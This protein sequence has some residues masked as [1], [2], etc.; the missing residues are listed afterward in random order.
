[1]RATAEVQKQCNNKSFNIFVEEMRDLFVGQSFDL[2][3]TA[4]L[5]CPSI[6]EYMQMIDGSKL[7]KSQ[8]TETPANASR[9][10]QSFPITGAIDDGRIPKR[11]SL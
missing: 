6:S 7:N 10:G 11:K 3:W 9:N 2:H 5:Q 1:M 4:E 8:H